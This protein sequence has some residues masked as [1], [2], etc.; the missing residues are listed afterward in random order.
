[1]R[2][3]RDL[4][5]VAPLI[6]IAVLMICIIISSV[7]FINKGSN[8]YRFYSGDRITGTFTM[9][10]AGDEYDPVE[11]ILEYENTGTQRLKTTSI[12]GFSIKG[13]KYGSYKISFMLDN[14]ELYRLTG[15]A[16]FEKQTSNPIL[17]FQYINTNWWHVTN[18]TLTA[19]MI[20]ENDEW[21]VNV[22]VVYSE[23]LKS[24]DIV[25]YYAEKSFTYAEIMQGFGIIQFGV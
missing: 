4:R 12:D 21:V 13:G 14:K 17:T 6:G 20:E 19:E 16:F 8:K 7:L 5:W 10:V 3:K 15:D 23:P 9:T 18:M 11:E 2:N 22:E 25:D 1:M 24:G